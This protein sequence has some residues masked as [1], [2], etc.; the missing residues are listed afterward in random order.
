M[1]EAVKDG[2]VSLRVNSAAALIAGLRIRM[3][4]SVDE[5]MRRP[6]LGVRNRPVMDTT[7][8]YVRKLA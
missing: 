2:A 6:L 7:R 5:R 3:A 1:T 8:R 4:D